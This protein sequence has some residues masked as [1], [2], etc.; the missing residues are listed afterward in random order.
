MKDQFQR[1]LLQ[2]ATAFIRGI[3]ELKVPISLS[4]PIGTGGRVL[5]E[6]Y[7]FLDNIAE[8]NLKVSVDGSSGI[9]ITIERIRVRIPE[10][11]FLLWEEWGPNVQTAGY[12]EVETR[13]SDLTI[14][15]FFETKDS[16]PSTA[17]H[18]LLLVKTQTDLNRW[19]ARILSTSPTEKTYFK[20]SSLG[21]GSMGKIKGPIE[22][23]AAGAFT[24]LFLE[25]ASVQETKSKKVSEH[26][27]VSSILVD[28]VRLHA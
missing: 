23:A 2:A 12:V 19:D 4:S 21:S 17:L 20:H 27:N 18:D 11:S 1:D 14:Q 28:A 5:E 3:R 15:F 9:C 26:K 22:N 8:K 24:R 10:L 13:Q 6:G 16:S 25:S 7:I